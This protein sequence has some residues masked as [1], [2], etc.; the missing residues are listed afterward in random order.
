[1]TLF[2]NHTHNCLGYPTTSSDVKM[3]SAHLTEKTKS[4]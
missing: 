3:T 2:N 4:K 1:M